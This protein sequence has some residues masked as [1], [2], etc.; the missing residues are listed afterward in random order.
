MCL[1][2]MAKTP[3]HSAA[4]P[5]ESA[6]HT[7]RFELIYR[8]EKTACIVTVTTDNTHYRAATRLKTDGQRISRMFFFHVG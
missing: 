8:N 2:N 1:S 7:G 6:G 5:E 3:W 4:R